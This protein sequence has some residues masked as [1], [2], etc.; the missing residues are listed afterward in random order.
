MFTMTIIMEIAIV[1][2]FIFYS[3]YVKRIKAPLELENNYLVF[4]V[5]TNRH[6]KV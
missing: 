6:N 3:I 1:A 2:Y 5:S 4:Y